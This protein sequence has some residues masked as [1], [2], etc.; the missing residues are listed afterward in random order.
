[1]ADPGTD[2]SRFKFPAMIPCVEKERTRQDI[3]ELLTTPI[4]GQMPVAS[5]PAAS[6]VNEIQRIQV[7]LSVTNI[8]IKT[9]VSAKVVSRG[10]SLI[11][12]E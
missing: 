6:M 11:F 7:Q 5:F 3:T 8:C 2:I 10:R 1:M 12:V 4:R 9:I